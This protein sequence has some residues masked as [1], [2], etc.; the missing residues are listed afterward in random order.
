MLNPNSARV[1]PVGPW[2]DEPLCDEVF[3][4]TRR[5]FVQD[6]GSF[7]ASEM[8]ENNLGTKFLVKD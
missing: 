4:P 8:S 2:G 6:F 1:L 5:G 7:A 3:S